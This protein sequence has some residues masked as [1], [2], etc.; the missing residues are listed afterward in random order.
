MGL[1]IRRVC[2]IRAYYSRITQYSLAFMRDPVTMADFHELTN[3][4][5]IGTQ[6]TL[7]NPIFQVKSL[8]DFATH[9]D[10]GRN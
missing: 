1:S 4:T 3:V 8:S 6:K 2:Y 5:L 10:L 7:S 9:R